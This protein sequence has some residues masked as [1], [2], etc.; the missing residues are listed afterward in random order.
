MAAA[1]AG[2]SDRSA[3]DVRAKTAKPFVGSCANATYI[4]GRVAASSGP[5]LMSSTMP[6]ISIGG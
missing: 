1:I 6:T 5:S 2:S 4:V 3:C